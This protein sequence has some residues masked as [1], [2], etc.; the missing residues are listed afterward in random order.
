MSPVDTDPPA[1]ES[2][3]DDVDHAMVIVTTAVDDVRSGCLVGFHSQC[4]IEPPRY[5]VWLSTANHTYRVA[6][7]AETFVVHFARP[8]DL[9]LAEVFGGESGDDVDKFSQCAW[10]AGPDGVPLL[11]ACPDRFVGRRVDLVD[12]GAD[13]A[14][15]VLAPTSG[16]RGEGDGWLLASQTRHIRAAH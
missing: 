15:L 6:A 4:G 1:F 8:D 5:A 10:T 12:V 3:M 14:C 9:T 16:G 7:R 13:H 11:D 2:L